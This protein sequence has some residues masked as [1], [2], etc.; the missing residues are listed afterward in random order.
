M[1]AAESSGRLDGPAARTHASGAASIW[2]AKPPCKSRG[3]GI[4]LC[5]DAD[6]LP[7][8][9]CCEKAQGLEARWTELMYVERPL[10]VKRRK[11][12]NRQW[13]LVTDWNPLQP[14]V[15]RGEIK[16]ELITVLTD[17]VSRHQRARAQ[18][19]DDVVDAFMAVRPMPCV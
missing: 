6:A 18:V 9:L 1:P 7:G 5:N 10:V 11:F 13:M 3:R 14:L 15:F 2:I 16:K 4:R 17:M 19:T 12:H 8:Y